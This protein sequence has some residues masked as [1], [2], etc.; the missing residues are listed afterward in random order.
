MPRWR[1]RVEAGCSSL[2]GNG[3]GV[4]IRAV[5]FDGAA[6]VGWDAVSSGRDLG[7][8]MTPAADGMPKVRPPG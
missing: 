3:A 1:R 4:A 2:A 5:A 8:L 6:D 7:W